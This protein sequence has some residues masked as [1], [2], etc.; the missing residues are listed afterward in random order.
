MK[1]H[2]MHR[3]GRLEACAQPP[4]CT[5]ARAPAQDTRGPGAP[6]TMKVGM[7]ASRQGDGTSARDKVR[8]LALGCTKSENGGGGLP[9]DGTCKWAR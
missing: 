4:A 5:L 7:P 8:M 9:L 3:C 1:E 2:G 6:C